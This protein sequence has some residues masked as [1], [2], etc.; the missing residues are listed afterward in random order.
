[1]SSETHDPELAA[2]ASALAAL[3]PSAGRLDRDQVLFRAGQASVG[4]RGWLWPGV[5]AALTLIAAAV[6]LL[7]VLRPGPQQVQCTVY[8]RVEPPASPA[9]LL[10]V[11]QPAPA[12]TAPRPSEAT[13]RQSSLGYLQLERLVLAWG[14][15]ALPNPTAAASSGE[16][17][18]LQGSK[19]LSRNDW[20]RRQSR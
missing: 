17:G 10:A 16:R 1:M 5:T 6:A 18:P 7:E 12:Y 9:E 14:V 15:D 2:L 13:D 4:Q 19:I 8:Q 20:L 3:A 11:K